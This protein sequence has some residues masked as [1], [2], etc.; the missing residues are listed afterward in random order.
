MR[1]LSRSLTA[2]LNIKTKIMQ[3]SLS[4]STPKNMF[5]KRVRNV[6]RINSKLRSDPSQKLMEMTV[7]IAEDQP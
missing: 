5:Y 2:F 1:S 3:I 4:N 6:Y 7:F